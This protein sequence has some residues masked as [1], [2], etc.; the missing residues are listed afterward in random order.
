MKEYTKEELSERRFER[1]R[2]QYYFG[3]L[4]TV[5]TVLV[6]ITLMLFLLPRSTE[7][8]I[9]N[10]GELTPFPKLTWNSYVDGS[11]T[12]DLTKWFSDTVPFRDN[13][14]VLSGQIQE[15]EGIRQDNVKFHGNVNIVS[16][17][18][19]H[20]ITQ[21]TETP[22]TAAPDYYGDPNIPVVTPAET[23]AVPSGEQ[24]MEFDNNG[25]VTIGDR[26]FMLFGGNRVQGK[27]YADVLNAYKAAMGE[28][29]NVYAM[30]VPTA[31]E[32]YLPEE[33]SEYSGSQKAQI[34]YIYDNL[35][36][37]TPVD[38]YSKLAAHTNEDIY[39]KTDHHWAQLGAYYASTA[40]AEALGETPQSIEGCEK[41]T[42]EGYV[43]SLY[44]YTNDI[45]IKESPEPFV[46][47]RQPLP[48]KTTFYKYDTLES[49]G[50]GQL[51]YEAAT[52]DN[53]YGMFI[54]MDAIHTKIVTENKNGKRLCVF[55]ESFGNALI[56]SLVP[57]FEEIYVIDI[58][59]FGMSTVDYMKNKGITDVLF[60]NNI[61]A[62]NTNL[63]INGLNTLRTEAYGLT[64]TTAPE[65]EIGAETDTETYTETA[66][67]NIATFP[68]TSDFYSDL[69]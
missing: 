31:V 67:D 18:E 13:I 39:L 20:Y 52:I 48:Y 54:G 7:S 53:S 8:V 68:E 9:E 26:S 65:T 22:M 34:D 43:G 3:A 56:P 6:S 15:L 66:P 51:I 23:A 21:A 27:Y 30:V 49:M 19:V 24:T 5:M 37:V 36:G 35:V 29:V 1:R 62:A 55:K 60:V 42:R 25:I 2:R 17:D 32:F 61:F 33:Y 63:L 4:L 14:L 12:R 64:I 46:Y 44:G 69:R 58:R 38:A 45:K 11:F 40:F 16:D 28:N 10:R 59:F 57:Y 50:A 41:V 47:Y